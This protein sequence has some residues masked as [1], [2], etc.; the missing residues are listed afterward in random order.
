MNREINK[1]K[2]IIRENMMKKKICL[3][4]IDWGGERERVDGCMC[5]ILVILMFHIKERSRS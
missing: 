2:E 3:C 1:L 4:K 5:E